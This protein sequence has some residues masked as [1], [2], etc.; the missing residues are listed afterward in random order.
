MI[1][2][3]DA[4]CGWCF[5]FSPVMSRFAEEYKDII[6]IEVVSG[7]LML[8]EK[9]GPIRI[10]GAHIPKAY[11]MVEKMTGVEFGQ[12]FLSERL[13][14]GTMILNSLPP[15]IALCIMKD[16][17]PENVVAFAGLMHKMYYVDGVEPEN[18][19][20]YGRYAATLGCNEEEFNSKM[21]LPEYLTKAQ[22]DFKY[23]QELKAFGFPTVILQKNGK[24]ETLFSGYRSYEQLK[25]QIDTILNLGSN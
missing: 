19:K 16:E 6:E 20:E 13:E 4:I 17:H 1:Y 2:V 14:E 5:G 25:S 22:E 8:G 11:Q 12:K 24:S 7:G 18:I 23:A 3:F 9:A 21:A 10:T 15:A